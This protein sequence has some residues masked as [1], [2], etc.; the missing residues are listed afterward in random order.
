MS[1]WADSNNNNAGVCKPKY[2]KC[3]DRPC[4]E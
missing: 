3:Y 1:I 4:Y 2:F